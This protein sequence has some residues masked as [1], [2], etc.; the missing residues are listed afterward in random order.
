M[1]DFISINNPRL[2]PQQAVTT[3]TNIYDIE[4]YVL[5]KEK[6]VDIQFFQAFDIPATFR[7]EVMAE[8]RFMGITA[9]TMFPGIDGVCEEIRERNFL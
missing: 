3:V 1:A 8:L 7:D 5:E 6:E 2:I 9:G 4:A